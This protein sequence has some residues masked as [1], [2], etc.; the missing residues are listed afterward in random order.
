MMLAAFAR[1]SLAARQH[2]ISIRHNGLVAE[3]NELELNVVGGFPQMNERINVQDVWRI[4]NSVRARKA[5]L[6]SGHRVG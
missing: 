2:C 3:M 4:L 1:Y 5:V 6:L